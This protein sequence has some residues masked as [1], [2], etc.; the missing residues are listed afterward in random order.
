MPSRSRCQ[1]FALAAR[2]YPIVF[3]ALAPVIPFAV[4]GRA[5]QRESVHRQERRSGRKTST[6]RRTC[7][8]IRSSSRK[9]RIRTGWS[10]ASTNRARTSSRTRRSRSSST[11]SRARTCK[12]AL[13]VQRDVPRQ[14]AGHP[15]VRRMA[16]S[17]RHARREDGARRAA[18][19]C[20]A[21]RCAGSACSTPRKMRDLKDE[22]ILELHKQRLVA[23]D[24]LPSA[25]AQQLGE[26]QQDGG[27]GR[28]RDPAPR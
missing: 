9:C 21:T 27:A 3:S 1:E 11:A 12:R 20:R 6:C 14:S 15:C 16:R 19:R 10:C 4:H 2:H 18:E 28:R 25:V 24:A 7:A 5:R 8:V 26:P 17:E 23:A 13:Q 22:Q